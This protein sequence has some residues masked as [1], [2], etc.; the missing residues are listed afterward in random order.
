MS[1]LS[2]SQVP[3]R[4][5]DMRRAQSLNSW[6]DI[7]PEED[8]RHF[9]C[10]LCPA[11]FARKQDCARHVRSVHTMETPYRC[12]GCKASFVRSDGRGRHWKIEPECH[13]AHLL[14]QNANM[15]A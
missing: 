4:R 8:R 5:F 1:N 10:E 15:N 13:E 3:V 12:E 2:S 11:R 7:E 14:A 6:K 9:Q